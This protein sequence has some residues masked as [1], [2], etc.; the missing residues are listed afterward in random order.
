MR[1]YGAVQ[2]LVYA[3]NDIVSVGVRGEIWRDAN[4]FCIASLAFGARSH[5]VMNN[6]GDGIRYCSPHCAPP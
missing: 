2:S 5:S 6:C 4:G 3:I 1:P